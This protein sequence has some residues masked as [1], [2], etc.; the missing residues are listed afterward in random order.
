MA[1]SVAMGV[2]FAGAA[3]AALEEVIVTATKRA[4][5][6]QDVPIAM[7]ALGGDSLK[8]LNVQTFDEYVQYLPNVVT[9]GI[10]PGSREV[11]IRGSASE[12]SSNT[13]SSAQGSAPQLLSILMKCP[14]LSV[15]VTLTY[16][17]LIS[18]V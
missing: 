11:Y 8:E 13:V 14:F 1:I 5:N 6:M 12:Q 10:A 9:A 3:N 2:S 7:S 17:P 15:H 4:E 16:M 18:S